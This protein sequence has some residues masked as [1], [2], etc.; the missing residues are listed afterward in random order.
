MSKIP[1]LKL[2]HVG[3]V[4]R[5]GGVAVHALRGVSLV[6]ERGEF[7][8]IVGQSGS[9]K[10]TLMHILGCLDRPNSGSYRI[11]GREVAT[12]DTDELAALR[13]DTFG[14]VF[15]QYNLLGSVT[16]A[17][18]VEI[19]AIYAGHGR[20]DRRRR[21]RLL[22]ERLGL[23]DR[24]GHRPHELS[25]GQQQR[26]SIARALMNDAETILADEPTGALDSRSGEEVLATLTALNREGRT[27]ILITH[28]AQV[29]SHAGRIIQ[30]HD[31]EIIEDNKSA[32]RPVPAAASRFAA[33]ARHLHVNP[34]SAQQFIADFG[35][36]MKM[37]LR[38]LRV[39]IFRTALTLLGVVIGVAAVITMLAIGEG[40]KSLVMD[41]LS[42]LG[43]NVLSIRPGAPGVRSSGDNATLTVPDAES[44]YD[45][46]N[47]V[48]VAPE[49]G[50]RATVRYGNIDYFTEIEGAWPTFMEVGEWTMKDGTFFNRADVNSYAPVAVLGETVANN[51][52]PGGGS[53]VGE[54]V[55]IK[56]IPFEIIGVL[57]PKGASMFGSDLDDQVVIPL[58]TGFMRVFGRQFASGIRVKIADTT[59]IEETEE[60]LRV[61]MLERHL[62]KEDFQIRNTASL[63]ET[64]E[65][66]SNTLTL[67]LGSV[68]AISLLVGGIGVMNIML[69]SVTERTREIGIRMAT[70]ARTSNILL[71]FNTE[72]VVVCGLG[73]VIGILLGFAV[74][75]LLRGFG[76][77]P[78]FTLFPPILAFSCAFF[79]GV[80]F[81]YLPARKAARLDPVLALG[82]AT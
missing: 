67:L 27:I 65:E 74:A 34:A 31:G 16:A 42:T 38:S 26:V 46:P 4:Y 76:M 33:A 73:G 43:T 22:L 62:G 30:I 25:G 64:A 29:A 72:A 81:G 35:E 57:S 58:T 47:V 55:L 70:G 77:S 3:K 51:L 13:R 1:F 54:Y 24:V 17:E 28:D 6:I 41:R 80:V 75:I 53:P 52:F 82:A 12:L 66:T 8:A 21:A 15:Q 68:A 48:A 49:R 60:A 23:G 40:S 11:D 79:T 50:T 71:Q 2:T 45:V 18:N 36:A 44:L 20:E 32:A 61:H 63:L 37:A 56:N 9:G 69:V 19:P 5:M 59:Q 78:V 10:S 7:V 14:F 39:N